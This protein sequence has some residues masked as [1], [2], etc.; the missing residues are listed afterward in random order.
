M[1]NF[2][3][4]TLKYIMTFIFF[5]T[6]CLPSS[7]AE[8][9]FFDAISGMEV[10]AEMVPVNTDFQIHNPSLTYPIC[11]IKAGTEVWIPRNQLY[12]GSGKLIVKGTLAQPCNLDV[13]VSNNPI[14]MEQHQIPANTTFYIKGSDT[15]GGGV[16]KLTTTETTDYTEA[17]DRIPPC[18]PDAPSPFDEDACVKIEHFVSPK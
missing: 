16:I 4:A 1:K 13:I 9:Y 10:R 14:K 11:N 6:I 15:A 5:G 3:L 12:S 7:H 2:S 17:D 18:N 8:E